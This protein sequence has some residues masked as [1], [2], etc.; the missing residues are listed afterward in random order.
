MS[1]TEGEIPG[2]VEGIPLKREDGLILVMD[3]PK[4]VA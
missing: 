1:K 4:G 2:G 3:T